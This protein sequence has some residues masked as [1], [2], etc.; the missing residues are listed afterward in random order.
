MFLLFE[1]SLPIIGCYVSTMPK[2]PAA[3]NLRRVAVNL[4][5]EIYSKEDLP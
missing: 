1:Y 2:K 5:L 3:I 4:R